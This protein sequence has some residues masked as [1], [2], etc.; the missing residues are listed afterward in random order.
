MCRGIG[1]LSHSYH[2][3]RRVVPCLGLL[4][5]IFTHFKDKEESLEI[6]EGIFL[7]LNCSIRGA[8]PLYMN[9]Q[10]LQG[11]DLYQCSRSMICYVPLCFHCGFG[12]FILI[13]C[14]YSHNSVNLVIGIPS[15]R[16]NEGSIQISSL[17][18]WADFHWNHYRSFPAWILVAVANSASW[19]MTPYKMESKN[20]RHLVCHQCVVD[21]TEWKAQL[22]CTIINPWVRRYWSETLVSCN[23][24]AFSTLCGDFKERLHHT[25]HNRHEHDEIT[26]LESVAE[27][28]GQK[29]EIFA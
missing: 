27:E 23:S 5:K 1:L 28:A 3:N 22:R 14:L 26:I 16:L 29:T 12:S 15:M 7:L 17:D 4:Q 24:E 10:L 2:L 13:I 8:L 21:H 20:G 11:S 18:V 9:G 25:V 19:Y 6:R